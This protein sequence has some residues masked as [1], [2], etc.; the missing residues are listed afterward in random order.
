MDVIETTNKK[1]FGY[2]A[3]MD[4]PKRGFVSKTD[5]IN[6]LSHFGEPFNDK[7]LAG[8]TNN[9]IFFYRFF[10]KIFLTGSFDI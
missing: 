3:K 7:E 2:G 9:K 5:L 4:I 10:Y 1:A 8:R 6:T